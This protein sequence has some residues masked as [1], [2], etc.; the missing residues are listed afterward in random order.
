M[1]RL[2]T[3]FVLTSAYAPASEQVRLDGVTLRFG[4]PIEVSSTVGRAWF[5]TLAKFKTGELMALY[6]LT[7]DSNA[8]V[9]IQSGFQISRDRRQDLESSL[10][11]IPG[12][13]LDHF[14]P[15]E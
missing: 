13:W 11:H 8:A 15:A 9:N 12:V 1:N 3:L 4:D 2:I 14:V 6:A 10:G 5:P 7:E